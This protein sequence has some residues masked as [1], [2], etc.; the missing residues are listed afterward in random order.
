MGYETMAAFYN[1]DLVPGSVP[2]TWAELAKRASEASASDSSDNGGDSDASSNSS[3][4]S[5]DSVVLAGLGLSAKYVSNA[6]DLAGLFFVQNGI[7]S[8]A[9][10]GDSNAAKSLSEYFAFGVS[11]SSAPSGSKANGNEFS[12]LKPEMD[13]LSIS[14]SDLFAR[15]KVGIV[16]GYPSFLREIQ[17]AI[18]RASQTNVLNKRNLKTTSVPTLD[19]KKSAN[20]ARYQ[21]FA[22]SKSAPNPDAA[23]EFLIHL[24]DKSSQESY[25][26]KFPYYLPARNELVDARKDQPVDKEFPRVKYESFLPIQGVKLAT[27]DRSFPTEF[28]SYFATV[29]ESVKSPRAA[30]SELDDSI[31]CLRRHLIEG[32]NFDEACT[33]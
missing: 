30:L 9:N 15:G 4:D 13:R 6:A 7:E 21:Y 2:A 10:F 23:L 11:E 18:K 5:S 28:A 8:A 22:L 29:D 25:L 27:F 19:P 24:S 33:K 20:L 32:A 12:R 26:S 17:Y 31:K 16:F 3:N 1:L 14:A